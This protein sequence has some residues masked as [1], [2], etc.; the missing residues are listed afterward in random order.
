MPGAL[1][2]GAELRAALQGLLVDLKEP[3]LLARERRLKL[4]EKVR[5]LDQALAG[6]VGPGHD[7]VGDAHVA[8]V[9]GA[10]GGGDLDQLG[11]VR[12]RVGVDHRGVDEQRSPGLQDALE[13]VV[14]LLVHDKESIGLL[15][16]RREDLL[17]RDDD[18]AVGRAA[19]DLGAVGGQEGDVLPL[20]HDDM[21]QELADE[22]QPL[23]A[24]AGH[25]Y[26]LGHEEL[27]H[28]TK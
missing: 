23:P 5:E 13:L 27:S 4:G 22:H 15:H 14:G 17:R 20:A 1:Q 10:L 2:G 6:V 7:H 19:A 16:E 28:I 18:V 21:G 9:R 26:A 24:G 12:R 25:D 8:Q 3:R 11:P